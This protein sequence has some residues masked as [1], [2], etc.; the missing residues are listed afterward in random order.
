MK[1]P[2][3]ARTLAKEEPHRGSVGDAPWTG[4]AKALGRTSN[5]GFIYWY[6]TE[7]QSATGFT[8]FRWGEMMTLVRAFGG[9]DQAANRP[10][11]ASAR[12]AWHKDLHLAGSFR[13]DPECRSSYYH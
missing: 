7:G 1:D 4:R 6:H 5:S 3:H 13:I 10:I 12:G 8:V 2:W 11:M 9:G